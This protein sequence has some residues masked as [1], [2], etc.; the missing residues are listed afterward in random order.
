[1]ASIRIQWRRLTA[2]S[3][4]LSRWY[5]RHHKIELSG[6]AS[7]T[8]W[9]FAYGSNMHESAFIERRGMRPQ[10]RRA[11]RVKGYRLRFNLDGRP[12]GKAAP[13]SISADPDAEVWGVLYRI[14]GHE[15]LR[16]NLSE[17]VPG[18]RYRPVWVNAEDL[19]G[20]PFIA[21]TYV[22]EGNEQDGRPSLRYINLLREGAKAHGLPDAWVKYLY[23]VEHAE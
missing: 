1:M 8:V 12:K 19:N 7:D 18:K 10:E 5:Y 3:W 23:G 15:M 4:T 17:G 21:F 11:G 16:L 14:T 2:K 9:Y 20:E 6:R 13:A 22:A